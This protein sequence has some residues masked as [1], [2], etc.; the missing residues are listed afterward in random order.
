MSAQHYLVA[1]D[2]DGTLLDHDTYQW[3]PARRALVYLKNHRIPVIFNTSK[4]LGEAV[5]LQERLGISGPVII[6]N[7]SAIAFPAALRQQFVPPGEKVSLTRDGDYELL[8][9]GRPRAEILAFIQ[10]TRDTL[11][12]PLLEG[13]HDWTVTAICENTGLSREEAQRSASKAFSEPFLWRADEAAFTSFTQR[14][15]AEGFRI[16]KGGRFFHLQGQTDKGKPLTWLKRMFEQKLNATGKVKLICLGDNHNDIDMLNAADIPVCV[17][18][19]TSPYPTIKA[20]PSTI[21]TESLGPAGWTEAMSIIF[22][23]L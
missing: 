5:E 7:G 9:F 1:A 18:S 2:L 17:K 3:Q 19:P 16:L 8:V 13:Y 10:R 4:T 20:N 11:N 22:P 23:D 14:A 21:L 6:E 15:S 12:A